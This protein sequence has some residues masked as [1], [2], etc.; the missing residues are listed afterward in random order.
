MARSSLRRLRDYCLFGFRANRPGFRGRF[1]GNQ[2]KI[3]VLAVGI[4]TN[5]TAIPNGGFKVI[6]WRAAR[7]DLAVPL[8]FSRAVS[9]LLEYN[10]ADGRPIE[11]T[12]VAQGSP[13]IRSGIGRN[14][15]FAQV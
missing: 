15:H 13:V 9:I 8:D 12:I 1:E 14:G 4:L 7:E 6:F 10:R 5:T 11:V 3:F 2:A